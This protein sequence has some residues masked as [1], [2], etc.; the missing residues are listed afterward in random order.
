VRYRTLSRGDARR[1]RGHLIKSEDFNLD[2]IGEAVGEG[3]NLNLTAVKRVASTAAAEVSG[4]TNSEEV[5]Q[6]FSG[7]IYL[8][9]RHVPVEVRDDPGFWRWITLG[10]L[11]TFTRIRDPKFGIEALGAGSN[12]TDI[13]ACRMFLRG[14]VS[15]VPASDGTLDFSLATSPGIMSHDFWQSHVLRRTTG[16]EIAFAQAL[17]ARQSNADTRMTTNELRPFVRDSINRKKRTLATFLMSHDEAA[18]Y[19]NDEHRAWRGSAESDDEVGDDL[20]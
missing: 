17:I 14:Q 5:E 19:L 10:S 18:V 12:Q 13:L 3:E 6:R 7:D 11:L 15:R 8:A 2:Q 1:V 16:A 4:G 20:D 9:L